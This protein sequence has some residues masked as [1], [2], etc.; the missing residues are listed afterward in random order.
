MKNYYEILNIPETASAVDIK[1]AYRNLSMKY[2]PDKNKNKSKSECERIITQINNAYDVLGDIELRNNYDES[3]NF[4][5]INTDLVVHSTQ[6][7]NS[8]NINNSNS[9]MYQSPNK[10][11]PIVNINC[12]LNIHISKIMTGSIEPTTITR[13]IYQTQYNTNSELCQTETETIYVPIP[14]GTDTGEIIIIPKKGNIYE[15]GNM[16]DVRVS[17]TVINDTPFI[18]QGLDLIIH[19]QLTLKESLCGFRMDLEHLT[20]T[21]PLSNKRGS[22]MPHG[23]KK[24]IPKYGIPRDEYVGNIIITFNVIFPTELT[25][26]QMTAIDNIL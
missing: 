2:H 20:G 11:R 25:E 5:T 1:H 8:R 18:R 26:D 19:K 3:L 22:I 12:E 6:S 14:K 7:Q 21:I 13:N 23:F 24:V 4:N 15:T 9:D 10:L 17:I 16:S